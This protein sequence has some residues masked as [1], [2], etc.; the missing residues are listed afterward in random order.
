MSKVL[1]PPKTSSPLGSPTPSPFG[2]TTRRESCGRPLHSGAPGRGGSCRGVL[3][4]APLSSEGLLLGGAALSAG[5]AVGHSGEGFHLGICSPIFLL[6]D[7]CQRDVLLLVPLLL[8]LFIS[9]EGLVFKGL[10]SHF[11]PCPPPKPPRAAQC[12]S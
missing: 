8:L 11:C 5:L 12:K 10:C 4:L 2:P 3:S 6:V 9:Q 7:V 1:A